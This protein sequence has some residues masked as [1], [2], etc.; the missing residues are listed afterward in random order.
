MS[1][2]DDEIMYRN[3]QSLIFTFLRL[4]PEVSTTSS[5]KPKAVVSP[6]I[7]KEHHIV[8]DPTVDRK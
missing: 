6:Q 3:Y 1:S 7:K 8:L 5:S 2:C 4:L